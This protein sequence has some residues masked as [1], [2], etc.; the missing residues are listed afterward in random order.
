MAEFD[1]CLAMR[2]LPAR[3]ESIWKSTRSAQYGRF[4]NGAEILVMPTSP[5]L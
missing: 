5:I 4:A 2:I 3:K 1:G